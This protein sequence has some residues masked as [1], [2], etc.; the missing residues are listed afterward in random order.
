VAAFN[1]FR[2]FRDHMLNIPDR[3]A[4]MVAAETEAAKCYEILAIEIRR[5]L[6]EFADANG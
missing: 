3:V 2:Q 4:A 5:A 1:K 6:N